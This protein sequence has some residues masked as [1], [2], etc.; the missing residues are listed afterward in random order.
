MSWSPQAISQR[1]PRLSLEKRITKAR[2]GESAKKN[3]TLITNFV[4]SGFRVFVI[5]IESAM[6][7]NYL[8][9][10]K[11]RLGEDGFATSRFRDNERVVVPPE[12]LFET[13]RLLKE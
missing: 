5:G 12:K 3:R 2:K 6:T 1:R 4:F 10:L 11:E 9:L 8:E 13:L 7:A